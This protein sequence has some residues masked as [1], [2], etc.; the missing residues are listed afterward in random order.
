MEN[1]QRMVLL[2]YRLIFIHSHPIS[3]V[4]LHTLLPPGPPSTLFSPPFLPSLGLNPSLNPCFTC[5]FY[6]KNPF[7]HPTS[8]L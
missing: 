3:E 2:M 4:E 6:P 5:L 8:S 1:P 7:L